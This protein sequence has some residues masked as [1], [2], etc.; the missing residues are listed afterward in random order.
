MRKNTK[1]IQK[2]I[3]NDMKE[4]FD[5]IKESYEII[6]KNGGN[7]KDDFPIQEPQTQLFRKKLKRFLKALWFTI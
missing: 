4:N 2:R 5:I 7:N 3:A 1:K 6:N